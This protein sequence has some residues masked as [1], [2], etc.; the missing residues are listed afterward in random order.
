M[1]KK[2]FKKDSKAVFSM[3]LWNCPIFNKK[4]P[5]TGLIRRVSVY[6]AQWCSSDKEH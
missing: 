2:R 3:V 5:L 6:C 1:V 4:F